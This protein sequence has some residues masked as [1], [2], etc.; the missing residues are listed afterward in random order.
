MCL[1]SK[2]K[3]YGDDL[4]EKKVV[5]KKLISLL[6]KYDPKVSTI[7]DTKDLSTLII[8]EL[9]SSPHAFEQRLASRDENSIKNAF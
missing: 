5:E 6:A 3:A 4:P 1:V 9:I 8:M 2:A 7:E